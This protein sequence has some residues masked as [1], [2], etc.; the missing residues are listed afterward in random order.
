MGIFYQHSINDST[1][2]G[3]W[4]I[5]EPEHFF[6]EKAPLKKQVTHPYKRLQHLAGRSLLPVLFSDFPLEDILIADTRKPYLPD[7]KYHFSISHCGNYA[8]AIASSSH[9]VG[10]DIELI[11][12]T[13]ARVSEKFLNDAEKKIVEGWASL[14]KLHLQLLTTLWSAKE[15]IYKWY[16]AGKVNFREHIRLQDDK[17]AVNADGSIDLRFAFLKDGVFPLRVEIRLLG[18]LVLAWT[19]S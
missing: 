17:I 12:P 10:V 11:S 19:V 5:E 14:P 3:V 1:K 15:A 13:V 8:A 6:L 18:N 2:L 4:K 16:G 9:R 7:E